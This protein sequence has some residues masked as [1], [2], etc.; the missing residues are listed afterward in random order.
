MKDT[1]RRDL[2]RK[3]VMSGLVLASA[4]VLVV[5]LG[6]PW[7][8]VLVALCAAVMAWEWSTVCCGRRGLAG[9][10]LIAMVATAPLLVVPFGGWALL[11]VLLGMLPALYRVKADRR[12]PLWIAAGS[13]YIGLPSIALAWIHLDTGWETVLW[14][15]L[16]V[17]TTDTA[18]YV[19]GSR[20]GG[21]LLW[22]RLSPRKT[23]AGLI[24]GLAFATVVGVLAGW[25]LGAASP[26]IVLVL[27][28]GLSIVSQGGDLL[29]SAFKRRFRVKDSG[30]LIPGHGGLLD[31]A[32]G[33]IAAT[34][35]AALAIILMQG[36]LTTW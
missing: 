18:A 10:L 24:G 27:A 7:F 1:G 2:L 32:D 8:D 14:L 15:F 31:R 12:R 4:V 16:V 28:L 25:L 26:G 19:V 35:V 23:W 33:L 17:W 29:E 36:G 21:P 11:P 5:V 3:R 34:P 9:S 20:V 6:W 13:L 22:P 30:G